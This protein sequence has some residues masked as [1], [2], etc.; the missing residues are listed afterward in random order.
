[1]WRYD[2]VHSIIQELDS[3]VPTST[4]TRHLIHTHRIVTIGMI[5]SLL[6]LAAFS[7]AWANLYFAGVCFPHGTLIGMNE[8]RVHAEQ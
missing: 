8:K 1:M 3:A 5:H 6:I 4:T 7:V 2:G